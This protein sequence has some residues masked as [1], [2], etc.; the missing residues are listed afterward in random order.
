M[1]SSFHNHRFTASVSVVSRFICTVVALLS[2]Y[3]KRLQ[4][5]MQLTFVGLVNA[6]RPQHSG[7]LQSRVGPGE[8]A[9]S[10]MGVLGITWARFTSAKEVM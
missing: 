5:L 8:V 10:Y 4:A 1:P 7:H 3:L 6:W 9:P 2:V